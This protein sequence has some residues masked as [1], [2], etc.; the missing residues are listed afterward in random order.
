MNIFDPIMQKRIEL[1]DKISALIK[2]YNDEIKSD[3]IE[4]RV[5]DKHGHP[6]INIMVDRGIATDKELSDMREIYLR[7]KKTD[8]PK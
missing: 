8:E 2:E 6:E 5:M 3:A 4:F 7:N 1:S